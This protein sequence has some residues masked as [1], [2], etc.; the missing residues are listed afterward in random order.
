MLKTRIP[1]ATVTVLL[2]AGCSTPTPSEKPPKKREFYT[3]KTTRRGQYNKIDLEQLAS[4]LHMENKNSETTGY[5]EK[6]FNT[7]QTKANV[8]P[9]PN[10]QN[11]YLGVLS[12]QM[13]CR[14]EYRTIQSIDMMPI[15][16][17]PIRWRQNRL[18]GNTQTDKGGYATL[19]FVSPRSARFGTMTLYLKG[20]IA[21]KRLKDNWRLYMPPHWCD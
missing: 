18:R 11:L 2:L 7:C 10:C 17:T 13:L 8:S 16:S 19:R 15:A 20:K 14:D 3:S 1:L 21:K 12:F 5:R 9:T 6:V 4:E